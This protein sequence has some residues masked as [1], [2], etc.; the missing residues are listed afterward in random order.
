MQYPRTYTV[1]AAREPNFIRLAV[2]MLLLGGASVFLLAQADSPDP[3]ET[4]ILMAGSVMVALTGALMI[5]SGLTS[6]VVLSADGVAVRALVGGAVL[7][8]QDI[9]GVREY[10]CGKGPRLIEL[11]ARN[12]AAAPLRLPPVWN[13][14]QAFLIWFDSLPALA[15]PQA[16]NAGVD[17]TP[18]ALKSPHR[19]GQDA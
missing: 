3:L 5:F 19:A 4:Q 16:H 11:V 15:L 1:A 17:P 6:R 7:Q 2:W 18:A 8:R 12:P 13:Q 10:P 14:D 9:L